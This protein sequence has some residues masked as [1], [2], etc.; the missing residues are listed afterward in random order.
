MKNYV[1]L[2]LAAPALVAAQQSLWGQCGGIGWTGATSCSGSGIVCSTLN[3]YYAQ[4]LSGTAATTT[5]TTTTS[6]TTQTTTPVTTSATTTPRTT[7]TTSTTTLSTTTRTTTAITPTGTGLDALIKAKGKKYVGFC[8]DP[9]TLSNTQNQNIIKAEGGQVTPENSM[10]WES[11]EPSQN[12]YNWGN[13]DSLVNFAQTNG[14]MIRGHTFV[15]YSQL[16]QWVS[17]INNKATLTSVIQSHVNTVMT[18]YK[19][20]IYAWDVANEVF[21]D[22]GSRRSS[23][24]SN[25][26]GDWT[27]LDVAF[28]AARAADPNAK[29]CLNDYNLDY[30]SAKLTN[31]VQLVKDLKNRGVPV[32]C[33][34]TQSHLIVGNSAIP[35]YKNTLDSL[36]TTNTEVQITELDIRTSSS[37]SSSQISQ[38]STDY[39]NVVCGCMKTS[40]CA[41]ITIW[42]VSD[43]DSWIPSVF[44]GQGYALLWDANFNKKSAYT[45][46]VSGINC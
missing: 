5:R 15:W 14:K 33:V 30:S 43:K 4:C 6:T 34:G 41:G 44:S 25:V 37:P 13:A 39:K 17:N 8:A 45:G 28:N 11:I 46:F 35:S 7:T 21:N 29:L 12:N 32:D 31:F 18:R 22:D 23:V 10:K 2:A 42:G 16:P 40:A 3:P 9:G 19:G 27:F 1:A 20:K 24:F 26:F 36:A 38:Q